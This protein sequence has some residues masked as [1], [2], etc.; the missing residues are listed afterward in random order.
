[1]TEIK[2]ANKEIIIEKY[3]EFVLNHGKEPDSIY[4]FAKQIDLDE[5][6][7]Y[8]YFSSFEQIEQEIF[9]VFASNTIQLLEKNEEYANYTEKEKLLSFYF[10][11]FEILTANRS[12][13]LFAMDGFK[14][15]VR[16]LK[17]LSKLKRE[18]ISFINTLEIDKIDLKQEKLERFQNKGY[19]E[20]FWAQLLI[21]LNFWLNDQSPAFEKTDVFIEKSIHA[22]FELMNTQP[23][24][25]IIDLGKFILKEKMDFKL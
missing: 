2:K 24:K 7:I 17:T 15:K 19:E 4:K 1:M 3:M 13:V 10:T 12:Y 16:S 18:F 8:Q 14:M 6:N 21:T 20:S 25:S 11:F 5:S 22:S 23:A 9:S